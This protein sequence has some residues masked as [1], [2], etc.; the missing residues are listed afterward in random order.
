MK[1][2]C[3]MAHQK[4]THRTRPRSEYWQEQVRKQRKSGL[5]VA[6]YCRKTGV[7]AERL[8]KW[9]RRFKSEQEAKRFVE[10][11]SSVP[12]PCIVSVILTPS[13]LLALRIDD[14]DLTIT[15]ELEIYITYYE[16]VPAGECTVYYERKWLPL[17]EGQWGQNVQTT[18]T[19]DWWKIFGQTIH[20]GYYEED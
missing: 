3:I 12:I 9:S 17:H 1:G 6:A 7:K 15:A 5:S 8:Y 16:W 2:G 19:V 18:A 10:L 14:I 20:I 13:L 4:Q 11:P